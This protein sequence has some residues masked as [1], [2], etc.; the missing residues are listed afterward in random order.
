MLDENKVKQLIKQEMDRREKS[1]RFG[2]QNASQ[3]TH[4]GDNSPKIP[5]N[6]VYDRDWETY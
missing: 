6:N 5:E 4:D 1:K 3:H 2:Y